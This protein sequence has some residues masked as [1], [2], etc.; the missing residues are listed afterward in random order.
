MEGSEVPGVYTNPAGRRRPMV[1]A[2]PIIKALLGVIVTLVLIIAGL[3]RLP[4]TRPPA[5]P[6]PPKAL[7]PPQEPKQEPPE[8]ASRRKR[9]PTR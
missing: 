3:G 8:R 2:L 7:P 6:K 4:T 5:A 1:D 9:S